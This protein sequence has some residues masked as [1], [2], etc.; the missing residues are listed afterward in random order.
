MSV[1]SHRH[2]LR[3]SF[4]HRENYLRFVLS[5]EFLK[6]ISFFDDVSLTDLIVSHKLDS[7]KQT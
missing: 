1:V 5:I 3:A 6:F 2:K 4:L 7:I